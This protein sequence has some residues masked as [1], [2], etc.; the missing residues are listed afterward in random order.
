MTDEP[1]GPDQDPAG[2]VIGYEYPESGGTFYSDALDTL[3]SVEAADGDDDSSSLSELLGM[4]DG[5]ES[6]VPSPAPARATYDVAPDAV[7]PPASVAAAAPDAALP[8]DTP[9]L[10]ALATFAP[11][12]FAPVP[13]DDPGTPAEPAPV[14]APPPAAEAA[15]VPVAPPAFAPPPPA[16][17]APAF[18]PPPAVE[19]P[20]VFAPPPAAESAPVFTP[21]P[22][23][24]APEESPEPAA[25]AAPAPIRLP[26]AEAYCDMCGMHVPIDP[27]RGTCHLGHRL[28]AGGGRK[29]RRG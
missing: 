5:D 1:T 18:A 24:A 12:A 2:D 13:G 19:S 17:S 14:F 7:E 25:P 29:G 16:E 4:F 20:P 3:E 28:D 6:V 23:A 8:M 27:E 22:P 10:V 21:P 11:S 26:A 15:P 9:S